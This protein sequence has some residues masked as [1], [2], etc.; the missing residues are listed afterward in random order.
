MENIT[1]KE[2]VAATGGRLLCGNET[3]KIAHLSIDSRTMKGND[4]FVPLIGE[5]VDAHRFIEQAFGAG[6]VA[7]L[8]SEHD[9]AEDAEHAWIRV[10][11]TKK[12]LQDI[13]RYYRS[14]LSLPLV[15]ITGSVGKTTTREMVAAALSAKYQVY[16]T[17][18]T[19]HE[20]AGGTDRHRKDCPGRY[21]CDHQCW[22]HPY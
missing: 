1:V 15:G 6:A 20:H 22:H 18:G 19:W 11:D 14:R 9:T 5:K 4:L 16:K 2:I 17:A 12:A 10:A 21:G 8:T 7:V 13:G 3:Q